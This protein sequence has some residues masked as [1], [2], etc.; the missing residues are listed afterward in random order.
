MS[1]SNLKPQLEHTK[2]QV[3][4]REGEQEIQNDIMILV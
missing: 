4:D 2:H 3:F 1:M